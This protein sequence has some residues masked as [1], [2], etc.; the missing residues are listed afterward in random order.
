MWTSIRRMGATHLGRS[1]QVGAGVALLAC[2]GLTA[3]TGAVTPPPASTPA[4][5][6]VAAL[7]EDGELEAGTYVSSMFTVPFEITVPEGWQIMGNWA[8]A[9]AVPDGE[10]HVFLTIGRAAYVPTDACAWRDALVEVDP[11]AQAFADALTA[12]ASTVGSPPVEV[13]VGEYS[14]LEFELSSE[15][16]VVLA[17]CDT[18]KVCVH[19]EMA[20]ECNR[21]YSTPT[22]RE[23]YRLVDVNG[24]VAV[25]S[26]G[27]FE[28]AD[29]T[30]TAEAR[31]IFESIAFTSGE[32]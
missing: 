6:T 17:D 11:T 25:I 27:E 12:Q 5:E 22:E 21:W 18:H 10:G 15:D 20:D 26:V 19:S 24:E 4:A 29:P 3:C 23:T 1:Q 30:H 9:K 31:A 14:G 13:P 32:K 16:D 2:I 28:P 8:L 7:P